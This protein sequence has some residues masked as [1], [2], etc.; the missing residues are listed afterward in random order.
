MVKNLKIYVV[1]D[2][3]GYPGFLNDWGLSIYVVS[4]YWK[5]LFDANMDPL[6]LQYNLE[7]L[8]L[9][10]ENLDFAVLSHHHRDHYGGFTLVG[11]KKPYLKVFTPPGGEYLKR[12]GLKPVII[13]ETERVAHDAY[14]IS[15]LKAWGNFYE[16]SLAIKVEDKGLVLFVGCSHPGVVNI[17]RKALEELMMKKLFLI[18]GGFHGPPLHV[19]DEL[20]KFADKICP[21][22]CSGLEI[23]EYIQSKYPEKYCKVRTGKVIDVRD[24]S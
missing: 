20:A 9:K 24:L 22:H 15:P 11:L 14:V 2:N 16:T 17:A 13:R 7:K 21:A 19:I 4:E 6:V 8:G 3:E 23:K 5:A 10:L 18:I 12:V 1:V